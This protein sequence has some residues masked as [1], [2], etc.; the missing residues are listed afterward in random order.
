MQYLSFTAPEFNTGVRKGGRT[1]GVNSCRLPCVD[2]ETLESDS[3][4][5]GAGRRAGDWRRGFNAAQ[6]LERARH[7]DSDGSAVGAKSPAPGDSGEC[8]RRA[9]PSHAV[10]AESSRSDGALRGSLRAVPRQRRPRRYAV[11]QRLVPEAAGFSP[12]GN[13]KAFQRT[14]LVHRKR[15]S[16]YW[17]AGL[18][19]TS[20][21]AGRLETGALHSAFAATDDGRTRKDGARRPERSGRTRASSLVRLALC[22]RDPKVLSVF[23]TGRQRLCSC[24][25]GEVIW[26]GIPL[27]LFRRSPGVSYRE[28][29]KGM[30]LK[31]W[32]SE[33]LPA[34]SFFVCAFPS[35][36]LHGKGMVRRKRLIEA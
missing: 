13:A 22:R 34:V 28:I 27:V 14:I 7:T 16:I 36:P 23:Q 10:R 12:G 8:P 32:S 26:A 30:R 3:S 31:P 1:R 2:Q 33:F 5:V 19:P 20:W 18:C 35:L 9:Q 29:R 15:I 24:I 11:R 17:H 25:V 21:T 6:R 4:P